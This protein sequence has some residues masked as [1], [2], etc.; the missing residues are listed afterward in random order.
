M[1]RSGFKR[2]T[3]TW[4]RKSQ[5]KRN[6]ARNKGIKPK[7]S[8]V[9]SLKTRLW[10]VFS[11]VIRLQYADNYGYLTT[12]DGSKMKWNVGVDCG[13]LFANSERNQQLGGNEL[14]YVEDNF[15]PQSNSGN[16]FNRDD[17]AKKYMMWAVE[18]YGMERIKEMQR[19]RKTYKMWTE[20]E[21]QEK[22]AYYEQRLEELMHSKLL[23][24]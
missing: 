23:P 24:Q 11:K 17:S 6:F 18:K 4:N 12:S 7:K 14:W 1:R 5:P 22:L 3:Y 9:K 13:H 16:R 19:M 10:K 15:A 2:K 20:E 8:R 21:L